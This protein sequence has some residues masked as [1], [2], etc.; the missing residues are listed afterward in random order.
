MSDLQELVPVVGGPKDGSTFAWLA[1]RF[2]VIPDAK[3]RIAVVL[4]D[5]SLGYAFG[6]H[7]YEL[8]CYAKGTDR[9]YQWEYVGYNPPQRPAS[10]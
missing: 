4:D 7:T 2:W 9:K 6:E 1:Q 10:E 3:D 8:K 5:G